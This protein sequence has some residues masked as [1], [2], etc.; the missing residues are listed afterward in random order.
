MIRLAGLN[1]VDLETPEP[2]LVGYRVRCWRWAG[3]VVGLAAVLGV[4]GM[5]LLLLADSS[6]GAWSSSGASSG[7]GS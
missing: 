3:Y 4:I 6:P 1:E 2:G 7:R 5:S